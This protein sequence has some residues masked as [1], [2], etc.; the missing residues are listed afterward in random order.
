MSRPQRLSRRQFLGT[1]EVSSIKL[2]QIPACTDASRKLVDN[3]APANY[4]P[5]FPHLERRT[6]T[7]RREQLP[8][9]YRDR[10]ITVS[11]R[12]EAS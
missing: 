3:C 6:G 4:P 11:P 10:G 9:P 8:G 1:A 5:T 7:H 12:P 2:K